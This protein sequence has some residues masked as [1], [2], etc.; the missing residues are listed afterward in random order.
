MVSLFWGVL[1]HSKQIHPVLVSVVALCRLIDQNEDL[2]RNV[3]HENEVWFQDV[4]G[5]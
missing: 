3:E 4:L 5:K 1:V 2:D